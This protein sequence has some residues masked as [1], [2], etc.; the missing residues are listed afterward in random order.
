MNKTLIIMTAA[1]TL[2]LTA[3]C[4]A[5]KEKTADSDVLVGKTQIVADHMT[6]ELLQELGKVSDMQV[7][8]DGKKVLYGVGYT[9]VKEDK[10]NRELFVLDLTQENAE[11]VQ[12]T[13]SPKSEQNA[14]WS[15]DGKTIYFLSSESGKMQMWQMSAD[16]SGRKQISDL[17]KDIEG[18]LLSPDQQQVLLILP[19]DIP[20]IDSTLFEGL[21]KT[22]G[23][24][25]DDMNYRHWDDFVNNC[26][27][28]FLARFGE[29]GVENDGMIDIMEGEPYECP[30]RPF[31]GIESFAW[32]P[33]GTQ[34]VYATRKE[35]GTRYAFSTRSSIYLYDIPTG[36][37]F[38]LH[39]GDHGYDTCPS[40]SPDGRLL[41]FQAMARNGY[42]S[43]KNALC[44]MNLE[45]FPMGN[46]GDWSKVNDYAGKFQDLTASYDHNCGSYV[47]APDAKS[48]TVLGDSYGTV[49][50]FSVTLDGNVKRISDNSD[51]DFGG[52]AYAGER[53]LTL[54]HDW[55]QPN[56]IFEL[57]PDGTTTQLTHENDALLAQLGDMGRIEKR[58]MKC[59]NGDSMLVWIAY[60]AGFDEA[61]AK[62]PSLKVPT[63]L[64]CE[65]G[66]ESAVSQFW[67]TRWNMAIMQA[68]GY[69]L[70]LPN[71]HGVP[72]F[73]QK[74]NE[75]IAGDF[76]GQCMRDYFTAIDNV[77][78]TDSWCDKD[79]LGAVGASF[80]G[81][82][83]Y[84]LAGH[85]EKRFKCFI[86]HCGIFNCES[87]YGETEE[88]WFADWDYGGAYFGQGGLQEGLC[89]TPRRGNGGVNACYT[90]SP[91]RSIL[92]WDTPILVIHN[93]H[94]YRIP[95]TQ[96]MQAFNLARMR[97]IPAEFLYFPDECHWVTHPQNAVLW[98]RV[99]FN[100]LDKWLKK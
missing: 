18:F 6:P 66:P 99:Y 80:G 79:R 35:T 59:T 64:Y 55:H 63:L 70:V 1:A 82:S 88:M 33:Q 28:P 22:T 32:N 38:D 86:A 54:R 43:D 31:G 3:S 11:P 81:Y 73:G 23:R 21:D 20:R 37:T 94:D 96:G 76:A 62:D 46:E 84:W 26:P 12:I 92:K 50:A 74:F 29:N 34:I 71:R 89:H 27:H 40:F 72:G 58:W 98:Q 56:E 39:L 83:V 17:D 45:G 68:H 95:V 87:M 65:G 97:G 36:Q 75:Q 16:G 2:A 48:L 15:K 19:L 60:P 13:H 77:A 9:S 67:S 91:H 14:V 47:W 5:K 24:L 57:H 25:W 51:H 30:M 93:E 42:E 85:H 49:Q 44:I 7:S 69:A 41:A 90:D 53:L 100:W 4:N 8:P 78:R 52:L 10:T 61:I